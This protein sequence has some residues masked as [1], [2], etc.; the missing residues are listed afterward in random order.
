MLL[1]RTVWQ[2]RTFKILTT[3]NFP[4][5]KNI[6]VRTT[7][8]ARSYIIVSLENLILP[9][10]TTYIFLR[11]PHFSQRKYFPRNTIE[12]LLRT[13]KGGHFFNFL[14]HSAWR[15]IFEFLLGHLDFP[16]PTSNYFLKTSPLA[17]FRGK[18]LEDRGAFCEKSSLYVRSEWIYWNT[19]CL[20]CP[21]LR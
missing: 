9:G 8:F 19:M 5:R 10:E 21:R 13:H 18:K 16:A 3:A 6:S 1:Y 20:I 11:I 2:E 12:F 17:A 4:R 14:T 7:I 15:V